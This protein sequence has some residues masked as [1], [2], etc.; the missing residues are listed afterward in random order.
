MNK[1]EAIQ[2]MREGFRVRHRYF[3]KDEWMT[4]VP[5]TNLLLL[6][7]GITI[8]V[9]E[10]FDLGRDSEAWEDGYELVEKAN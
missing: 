1:K 2:A 9:N 10:F 6:E 8:F 5:N 3:G 7:D 4:I